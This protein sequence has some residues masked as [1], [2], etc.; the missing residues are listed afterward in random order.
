MKYFLVIT[1]L[2]LALSALCSSAQAAH[3]SP[4]A[5]GVKPNI[6][7]PKIVGGELANQGDWPWMSA[8]VFTQNSLSSSL[9]I[10]GNQYANQAFVNSPTGNV[11]AAI[12]DC[13]IGNNSCPLAKN[14]ICLIARGETNF[15]EKATNC[16]ASGG[17]AAII[18]NNS[19]GLIDGTLGENFVGSIPVIAISQADGAALLNNLNSIATIAIVAQQAIAKNA[20]CGASF[21]GDKWLLTAAHCVDDADINFLKV[22]VGAYDLADNLGTGAKSAQ[23]IKRIY[24]HPEYNVTTSFNNDIALIELVETVPANQAAITLV[25]NDTSAQ[26]ALDNSAVTVIGWGNRT[27]YGPEDEL[28]ANSQ[29]NKLHQVELSLLTNTQCKSKLAQAYTDLEGITYL[30]SQVGITNNM[31][32]AESLAT[33]APTTVMLANGKGS[34]QGDSGG[35]LI[36]ATNQGWQQIGIVSY[37][38]GCGVNAFPEVYARVG[39]FTPWINSIT[40]GIAIEPNYH[41]AITPQNNLQTTQLTV[42]NHSDSSANLRFT[43]LAEKLGSD[44]FSLNTETCRFLAAKQSCQLTVNFDAKTVGMHQVRITIDSGDIPASHSIING[45]VIAPNHDINTQL[46]GGSNTL[47]WFSGGDKPW[48]PDPSEAAITSGNIGNNQQ[49]AVLLNFSGAGS[50]SFEWAVSSEENT[51]NANDPFD[52]LYLIVD[53]EQV[54]FISGGVTNNSDELT[55]AQVTLDNLAAGEHNITWL[56]K[57][58]AATSKGKDQGYLRNVI[59][60]P[61]LTPTDPPNVPPV[62]PTGATDKTSSGGSIYFLL[63][64]LTLLTFRIRGV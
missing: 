44:G 36:V 61:S 47:R 38:V 31:I 11:S 30:P 49:S 34:C 57:K 23:A 13:G 9:T 52:A 64:I 32:C 56:Y 29:P 54:S 22:K 26:L 5:N 45:Q 27:P 53:G 2:L 62:S 43:L 37:G 63:L 58:D 55:Y 3:L 15:S 50:L 6:V 8:L 33:Q 51:T 42:T 39:N 12:V 21:I 17:I 4:L 41:F 28:P 48:L 20:S 59:F 60:T 46:S 19:V 1:L 16:Q 18:Y 24:I 40:K 25:D 7:K 35:P 10:A 14:K